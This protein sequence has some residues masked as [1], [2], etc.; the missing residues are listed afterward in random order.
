MGGAH[1]GYRV[2]ATADGHVAVAALE[3]HFARLLCA[4][5]SSPVRIWPREQLLNHLYPDHRVVIDRTVDSHIKNLRRKLTET[6][7]QE[8]PIRSVYGV[9]YRLDL[10][11]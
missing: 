11:V 8:D 5:A 2:Y 10:A 7:G 1:A 3:P 6:G 4:L 9:G